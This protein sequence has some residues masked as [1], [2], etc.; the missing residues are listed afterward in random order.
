M[1]DQSAAIFWL[2]LAYPRHADLPCK[3]GGNSRHSI[4]QFAR[5]A[6]EQTIE[7]NELLSGKGTGKWKP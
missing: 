7:Y 6:T 4:R 3:R 2:L 1:H 5:L